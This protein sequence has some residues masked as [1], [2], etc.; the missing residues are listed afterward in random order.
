MN[1]SPARGGEAHKGWFKEKTRVRVRAY[2]EAG[3]TQRE[4]VKKL[5]EERGISVNQ[6]TISRWIK[7]KQNRATKPSGRPSILTERTVRYVTR[8]V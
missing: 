3:L 7:A 8:L 5:Q 1:S 6:S 2:D 4:I